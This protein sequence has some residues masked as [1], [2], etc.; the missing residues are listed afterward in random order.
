MVLHNVFMRIVAGVPIIAAGLLLAGCQTHTSA[1]S[2]KPASYDLE[3]T[4]VS[5]FSDDE[6]T[7][8]RTVQIDQPFELSANNGDKLSGVLYERDKKY[9]L[10]I[11]VVEPGSADTFKE[12][13][14]ELG[15]PWSG[16]FVSSFVFLRII[17]L[18]S[19]EP[20]LQQLS[21]P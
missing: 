16:G 7:M 6:F 17:T 13:P 9:L 21:G 1:P 18:R 5:P 20:R 3:V 10:D 2:P 4:I 15:K 8:S 19:H 11:T 12:L 14:L